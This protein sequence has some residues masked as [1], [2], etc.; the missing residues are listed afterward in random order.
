[1]KDCLLS[2]MLG[3][4]GNLVLS[5]FQI[6]ETVITLSRRSH[7]DW[8]ANT[9]DANVNNNKVINILDYIST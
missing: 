4:V 2:K 5:V 3:N 6:R 9:S 1:M 7:T 8:S